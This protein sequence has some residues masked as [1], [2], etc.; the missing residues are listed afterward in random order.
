MDAQ[1]AH[2]VEFPSDREIR[3]TRI[4]MAPRELVFRAWTEPE[5]LVKWWGPRGFSMTVDEID[6]RPEGNWNFTFHGPDGTDY[7]NAITFVAIERPSRIVMRHHSNPAFTIT[8]TFEERDGQTELTFSAVFDSAAVCEGVKSYAVPGN[9]QTLDR[10]EERVELLIAGKAF[11]TSR[12]FDAPR[13][14]VWKAWT[15]LDHLKK[16]FG[17]KGVTVKKAELDLVEG[18]VFHYCMQTPD[19]HEMWGKWVFRE[20]VPPR[21]L[22]LISSFS[23]ADGGLTRHP[24][25]DTWPLQTL[26][27]TEFSEEDGKT[28]LTLHWIPFHAR[29]E[30]VETFLA[31]FKA[32]EGGW[33]GT[34]AQLDAYLSE[35]S[36]G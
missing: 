3:S 27:T 35:A 2:R 14:L 8:A 7:R 1:D 6:I 31:S 12:V 10:L 26:S 36:R 16:W 30:E 32:M 19:G 20:I 23:D 22:V 34:M 5:H 4:L 11:T 13:D 25:S 9:R 33:G 15:D 21:K 29:P 18:G 17:P 28:R 24:L